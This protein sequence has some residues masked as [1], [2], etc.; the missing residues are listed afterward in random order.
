MGDTLN[1]YFRI[2]GHYIRLS[3]ATNG[4]NT[5][6]LL[7]SF[8][9]FSVGR[10][11]DGEL[12]LALTVDD[13]LKVI[14]E[15]KLIR[16][17][18]TGNGDTVV[19]LLPDGGY[20]F[21]IRDVSGRDC[22][23]LQADKDFRHCS[24]ALNGS[25]SMRTFGFNSALMLIYAYAGSRKD[26]ALIHASCVGHGG[27]AYPF[28]AKSGTGKSTHVSLW[29]K[30]IEGCEILND[31]NPI[32][33]VESDGVFLYGSPWSGKTPCYRNVRRP[34]GAVTRI[35]RA[36][37][38]SIERLRPTLAFASVLPACSSMKWDNDIY[39][40]LCST[41]TKIIASTPIYTLHCLPDEQA[42][43]LC[44]KTISRQT[45]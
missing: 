11:N 25:W 9:P 41:V 27:Y 43:R 35:E 4:T 38:N 21:I 44:Y 19:H 45:D 2:G 28:I 37:S 34:L 16:T 29:M 14:R 17:F 12:L 8:A 33:H 1:H 40:R 23:L 22:C 42:A 36:K 20:Q 7:P 5:M 3:F 31:D 39:D 6:D 32:V 24:C 10:V 30:H 26:T 13:T 18:D 15:R